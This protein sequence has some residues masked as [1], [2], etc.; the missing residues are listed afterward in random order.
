MR[1][2]DRRD[3]PAKLPGTRAGPQ[4][5]V[6]PPEME[7]LVLS[8]IAARPL[9]ELELLL[10]EPSLSVA[11]S[12]ARV[13]LSRSEQEPEHSILLDPAMPGVPPSGPRHD[14]AHLVGQ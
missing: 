5:H 3:L 1:R 8:E 14:D 13:W 2:G 10:D 7:Q 6:F 4:A 9:Q 11:Q 12:R